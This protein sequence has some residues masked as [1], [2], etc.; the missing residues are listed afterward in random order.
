MHVNINGIDREIT[1]G[2]SNLMYSIMKE[3]ARSDFM[4]LVEYSGATDE[5]WDELKKILTDLG[6]KTYL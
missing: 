2:M 6:L 3:A 1:K 5:D 4:G